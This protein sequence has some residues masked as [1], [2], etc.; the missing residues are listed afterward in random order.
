[1]LR[2]GTVNAPG[3]GKRAELCLQLQTNTSAA[4][5]A[6][7]SLWVGLQTV[8]PTHSDGEPGEAKIRRYSGLAGDSTRRERTEESM[9]KFKEELHSRAEETRTRP[10]RCSFRLKTAKSS[11]VY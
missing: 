1:M 8:P 5:S 2:S 3:T 6:L 10:S 9:W 11:V 4:A 7:D